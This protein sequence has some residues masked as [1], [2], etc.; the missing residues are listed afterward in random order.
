E[1]RATARRACSRMRSMEGSGARSATE[2][3]HGGGPGAAHGRLCTVFT[4]IRLT[5]YRVADAPSAC[6]KLSQTDTKFSF[7]P[8]SPVTGCPS[9]RTVGGAFGTPPCARR[10]P[11]RRTRPPGAPDGTAVAC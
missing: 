8:R 4:W 3:P 1:V 9:L 11:L 2:P 6:K 7:P 5:L 10:D